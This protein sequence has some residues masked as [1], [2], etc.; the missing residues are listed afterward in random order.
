MVYFYNFH[1][2]L[3]SLLLISCSH[4]PRENR[5]Q[6]EDSP[7]IIAVSSS[8]DFQRFLD[9]FNTEEIFQLKRIVFPIKVT[10]PDTHNEGMGLMEETVGKYDWE[11]LDLTYDT[12]YASREYD[13]YLQNVVF[14]N[15]TAIVEVRGIDN[16]IYADY[17]FKL[18]NNEWFLVT[19][20]ESSF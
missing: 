16:G 1:V 3:L 13:R 4:N 7:N 11:L 20:A 6:K 14:K 12:T 2:A 19:L 18:I 9:K 17:Y 8:E 5:L 10:I 15:D